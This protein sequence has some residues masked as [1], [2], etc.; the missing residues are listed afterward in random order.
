MHARQGKDPSFGRGST[1]Y[2]R[3]QGDPAQRPN[4]CVAP[5]DEGPYYAVK[6][7]PGSFGTF[8]GLRTNQHAQVLDASLNPIAGLY[9]AGTDMASI[10]G[11]YYPAG[12]VNLGPA[13]AFGHIAGLHVAGQ[14]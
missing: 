14:R 10:M 13:M 4:P 9:A 5:L 3:K 2:N 7:V 8:A 11:G 1:P 6:V 12:G